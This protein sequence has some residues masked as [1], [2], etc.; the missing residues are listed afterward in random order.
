VI[1]S[2]RGRGG[3]GS[4]AKG[5]HRQSFVLDSLEQRVL[6]SATLVKDLN[7][8]TY[9]VVQS[10]LAALNGVDYFL[11]TSSAPLS[12]TELYR[13]DGTVAGTAAVQQIATTSLAVNDSLLAVAGSKL[14]LHR[15]TEQWGHTTLANRRHRA[16]YGADFR[17]DG[18][19]T[20]GPEQCPGH[21]LGNSNPAI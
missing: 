20:F 5:S 14:F 3:R 15:P 16:E 12:N 21:L 2:G 18:E 13:T 1:K 10:N 8:L 17:P 19:S 6:L 9:G 11:A 7:P 4:K